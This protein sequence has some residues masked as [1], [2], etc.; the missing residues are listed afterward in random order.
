[1]LKKLEDLLDALLEGRVLIQSNHWV[2][3]DGENV[4]AHVIKIDDRKEF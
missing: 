4:S 1:M 2:N 3:R